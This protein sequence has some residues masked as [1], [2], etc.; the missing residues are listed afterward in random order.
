MQN[1]FGKITF[2]KF[3]FLQEK[4]IWAHAQM[5][6]RILV[7]SFRYLRSYYFFFLKKNCSLKILTGITRFSIQIVGAKKTG[8]PK[9]LWIR[10]L[11]E[12]SSIGLLN[13]LSF[14]CTSHN[15]CLSQLYSFVF[16]SVIVN[17]N[18]HKRPQASRAIDVWGGK[19]KIYSC[20]TRSVC[21]TV[22]YHVQC[23]LGFFNTR[24]LQ[25]VQ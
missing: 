20:W 17:I 23:F 11:G 9:I 25:D 7:V 13:W 18:N 1:S 2:D 6:Q 3:Q 19:R 24:K 4:K 12:W 14:S 22:F 15:K 5:V 21:F 16:S 10:P 8:A